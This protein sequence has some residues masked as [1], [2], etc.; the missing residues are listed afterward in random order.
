[1]SGALRLW[2]DA[3]PVAEGGTAIVLH[4]LSRHFA[5]GTQDPY[6]ALF[7]ALRDG[8]TGAELAAGEQAAASDERALAAYRAGR[9]CHPLLPYVDWD[10]CRPALDRL[11]AVLVA[12]AATT[13]PPGRS[14]SYRRTESPAPSRWPTAAPVAKP[15]SASS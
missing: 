14:A 11:G 10:S 2:R 15:G 3:F 5:H 12:A 6:R 7:H 1:M 4:R 8:R 13:R 9:A